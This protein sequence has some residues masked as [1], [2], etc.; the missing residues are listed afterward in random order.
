MRDH[1][2][3]TPAF[4]VMLD[5]DINK[6]CDPGMTLRDRFAMEVIPVEI[7]TWYRGNTELRPEEIFARVAKAAYLM[8]DAML[9]ARNK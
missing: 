1:S 6:A 2:R 4:P 7:A 9:V 5:A 3:H 8:A